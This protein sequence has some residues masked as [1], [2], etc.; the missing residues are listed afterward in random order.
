[1]SIH[2]FVGPT[3]SRDEVRTI[4]EDAEVFGPAAFG[5]VY[6]SAKAKVQTIAI[7]DGYFERVP[8]VWHKEILWAMS[9]GVHVFGASSMGALRAAELANFGMQ[10]IGAIYEA[11]RS[12]SLEDDDEVTIAH[13]APEDG[14]KPLS[15][16]LVNVRA[17]VLAAVKSGVVS[18]ETG[19]RLVTLAKARF[20]AERSLAAAIQDAVSAG[21]APAE[22]SALRAWL[23]NGR[24][25]QKAA[26]ARL[27]LRHIREWRLSKPKPLRVNYRLEPT[28]AWL[29]AIRLAEASDDA[30]QL[31]SKVSD[32]AL[33]EELKLAGLYTSARDRG[34]ARAAAIDVARRAGFRPDTAALAHAAETLRRDLGL[35]RREDFEAWRV[36]ERIDD[37]SLVQLFEDQAQVLWAH[38]QTEASARSFL[39][40]GLR[41]TSQY[42]Q[43]AEKVAAKARVLAEL[44]PRGPA[45][46]DFRMDE[47]ALWD[48]YFETKLG[49]RV[50]SDL[51]VFARS[52]GFADTDDLRSAVLRELYF[53][54]SRQRDPQSRE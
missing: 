53:E 11:Y 21:V 44:G 54:R 22:L 34:A 42:G 47:P 15:E 40:D 38:P 27:L 6:R 31:A 23:P 39:A 48:W 41:V 45:L 24:V 17:T 30:P 29:E 18:R 50:P 28:N 36:R 52:A 12:G 43:F 35:V 8:A 1:V 16:A 10:G 7:I 25:D 4:L 9:E 20:Y 2:V 37:A 14:F 13:G 32:E 51:H 3:L 19:E 46:R 49:R 5:D 26:D 33:E